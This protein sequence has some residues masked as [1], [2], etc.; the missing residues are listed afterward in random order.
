[1]TVTTATNLSGTQA[2]R[3]DAAPGRRHAGGT[4]AFHSLLDA[5]SSATKDEA[6]APVA[7]H[8]AHGSETG[9]KTDGAVGHD[10]SRGDGEVA[11]GRR[12]KTHGR[13]HD[14]DARPAQEAPLRD[15]LPLL[16][17]L[18]HLSGA[19]QQDQQAETQVGDAEAD[20][21]PAEPAATGMLKQAERGGTASAQ[22]ADSHGAQRYRARDH[23]IQSHDVRDHGAQARAAAVKEAVRDTRPPAPV[24]RSEPTKQQGNSSLRAPVETAAARG[25]VIAQVTTQASA[26]PDQ[27][28][29][30]RR[31][32][33]QSDGTV[34]VATDPAG[35]GE[36]DAAAPEDG[37][38]AG[39]RPAARDVV[40]LRAGRGREPAPDQKGADREAMPSQGA[41]RRSDDPPRTATVTVTASQSFA[42]PA[43]LPMSQTTAGLVAAI[44]ADTGFRQAVA[45]AML[46]AGVA[47]PAHLLKIELHPAELGSVTA[48][49]R[50]TG[51]QLSVEIKPETHEA[52]RRLTADADEIRKSLDRLGLS[53]DAVT[54]L[55]PQIAATAATRTD[56]TSSA[57]AASGQNQASFQSGGSA[58]NGD[59][60]NGQQSG[61]NRDDGRQ[62]S[63]HGA[64]AP[65]IRSGGGLFI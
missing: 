18:Q 12:D 54:V 49:L 46:P 34:S 37:G 2:A 24:D 19:A 16:V 10:R 27:P 56:M 31:Q 51:Q 6:A 4:D 23:G 58:G 57:T 14:A 60:L 33:L 36:A 5:R 7:R 28:S 47:A 42:A 26:R 30:T 9:P 13:E 43:S 11:D 29:A 62:D 20:S 3:S 40:S 55:Q 50:L 52:Y 48:S 25:G 41:G 61:R 15:R 32:H 1:M 45:N 21:G 8:R 44:G 22:A 38:T 64:T 17:S 39:L 35:D 63:S 53:V 65:R 59:G